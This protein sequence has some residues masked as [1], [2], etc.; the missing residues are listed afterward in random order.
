MQ[1]LVEDSLRLSLGREEVCCAKIVRDFQNVPS[2]QVEKHKAI[3]I[4]VNLLSNAR[5]A[6]NESGRAEKRVTVRIATG[7]GCIRISVVDN[8]VGIPEENLTRI[9]N[10]GFTTR[11]DGHGFGLHT[12]SLA[13]TQMGGS[14]TVQSDGL[15][16]GASFTLQLPAPQEESTS[17]EQDPMP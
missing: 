8:G 1:S 2:I 16:H 17:S 12:S 5:H 9:F 10:H 15:G 13:A 11:K 3:E 7:V 4:L 14:L 6:C